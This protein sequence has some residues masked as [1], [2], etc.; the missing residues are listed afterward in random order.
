MGAT[1]H[2]ITKDDLYLLAKGDWNRSWEKMGAHR[3]TVD[4]RDGYTFAVWAPGVRKVTVIGE[5]NEWNTEADP[6]TETPNGGVWQGFVPGAAEGQLYKFYILCDDGSEQYKA[7][8]Y[9]F[10]SE[11]PPGTASRLADLS[12]HVWKDGLWMGRRGRTDHFKRPLNIYE[13]H[14]GS[15][16]RHD[17]GL[18]GLGTG[19]GG[20]SYLTYDELSEELVSY[21][22]DMGYTHIELMPVMEHP[23]DGSWGYQTTGYYAP[24][25]RY[26]DP[27]AFMNFVDRCHQANIG[28]ILDWVPGGF[29]RDI[30]GLVH[31][32]GHKLYE[33]EE[34]PNWGTYKFDYARGEVRTFLTSNALFWLEAYHADGIRMDGVTSMLYLNFGVD[35]PSQKKFNEKG[36]EEDLVAIDFVRHVNETVGKYHPD[37][38]MMAEESTAWPL[39]TRPAEVGGLG[40]HYKWDMGWMNDTLN[41]C[42]TDFPYRPGNHNLLTF[43]MM[44]AYSENYVL[45]LSHDEVVHGKASLI[46]RQPGDWWRQFAGLRNLAFYQMTHP[47]AKLNFM[48]N[49]IAQFI[50]WRYYEGIQWFLTD[51]YDTHRKFQHFVRELNRFFRD[52]KGLWQHNYDEG[53][54]EWIDADNSEQSIVSYVRHG[55]RPVDDRVVVIN[56]DPATHEEFRLGVPREGNYVEV[57]NTDAVEFGGSG[58]INE[59]TL[60]STPTATDRCEDSIVLRVPPLAGVV[61]KRTGKSSHV[62]PKPKAAPRK[63]APKKVAPAKKAPAKKAPAKAA[64]EKP[65]A[66]KPAVKKD[67]APKPAPKAAAPKAEAAKKAEPVA[68]VAEARVKKAAASAAKAAPAAKK[69]PVKKT[70]A[71][72]PSKRSTKR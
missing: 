21:V 65:A 15:W 34:H 69:A 52:N 22:A 20:G 23:F 57:F 61:L 59:G 25:A 58:V 8:P 50:E 10:W 60:V 62:A 5:F 14:L 45:P 4:G 72:K 41:Y 36:T 13:V 70:A 11:C 33:K 32:N 30:Q 67:G 24:T 2:T 38:M 68:S 46:Q 6:L 17:D 43:S 53:G 55:D 29:C 19:E 54:F 40:F 31:F 28:V 26:G 49:E 66:S 42:K 47:G 3:A 39:V 18:D 1:E 9:A 71:K 37:A 35:D 63:A 56:F 7:D 12:G 48:G 27:C 44:Y 16:R 51:E 64:A